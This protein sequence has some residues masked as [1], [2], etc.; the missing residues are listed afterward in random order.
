MFLLL[1]WYKY[2]GSSVA[3]HSAVASSI[4]SQQSSPLK[5]HH[6]AGRNT[7]Y[8]FW[9]IRKFRWAKR[10]ELSTTKLVLRSNNSFIINAA[11]FWDIAPLS[12]YENRRFG[13]T[14]HLH[15]QS[16]SSVE[17]GTRVFMATC[18]TLASCLVNSYLED[19]GDI[20]LRNVDSHTIYTALHLGRWQR[21]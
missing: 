3:I 11:I 9:N 19:G 18:Y 8:P 1:F 17:K 21:S 4:N 7:R 10:P 13:G 5:N 12:P 20:S 2:K 15:L 14:Y 16:R 6:E